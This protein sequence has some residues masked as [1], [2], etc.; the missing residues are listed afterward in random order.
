MGSSISKAIPREIK[1]IMP[2]IGAIAGTALLP[3]TGSVLGS[4]LA[5]GAGSVAGRSLAAGKLTADPMDLAAAAAG[6]AYRHFNPVAGAG[7]GATPPPSGGLP[8][9]S[10]SIGGGSLSAPTGAS[11]GLGVAGPNVAAPTFAG[12]TAP[13]VAGGGLLGGITA[14]SLAMPL[15]LAAAT[16]GSQAYG[17][18]EEEKMLENLYSEQRAAVDQTYYRQ[19]GDIAEAQDRATDVWRD[20]AFP[21]SALVKSK[22]D[23]SIAEVNRRS[24]MGKRAAAESLNARG[25][26]GGGLFQQSEY[27]IEMDR[28]RM[29]AQL[30]SDLAQFSMTPM[31]TSPIMT[32]YPNMPTVMPQPYTTFGQRLA[33]TTEGLAGTVGGLWGYNQLK[34]YDW[35]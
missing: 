27:E 24:M 22:R 15:G 8:T 18:Q 17:A 34:D 2:A 26:T 35:A 20:T 9:P 30:S 28:Q 13:T 11:Y 29:I 19:K 1:P 14:K 12:V 21:D 6:G 23:A 33:S 25:I 3:G 5:S 10:T 4:A 16:I 7:G 31:Q 32:N